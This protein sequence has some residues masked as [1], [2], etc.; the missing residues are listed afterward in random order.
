MMSILSVLV[1]GQPKTFLYMILDVGWIC[2]S[3]YGCAHLEKQV[4]VLLSLQT[5]YFKEDNNSNLLLTLLAE[6]NVGSPQCSVLAF[7]LSGCAMF[8]IS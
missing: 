6:E 3:G 5:T 8:F 2:T 7:D 4:D 1:H